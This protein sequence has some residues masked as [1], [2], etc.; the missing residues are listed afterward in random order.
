MRC[1]TMGVTPSRSHTE[2]SMRGTCLSAAVSRKQLADRQERGEFRGFWEIP[3][4]TER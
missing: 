3:D 2:G 4:G 1:P